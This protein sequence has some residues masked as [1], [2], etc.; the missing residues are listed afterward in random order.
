MATTPNLITLPPTEIAQ[1]AAA[2]L[3]RESAGQ[4]SRINAIN[5]SAFMLARGVV[6]V[7]NGFDGFLIASASRAGVIHRVSH[8][9]GCNC[10]AGKAGRP[11]WHAATVEILERA[12]RYTMPALPRLETAPLGKP[13]AERIA[14]ARS[15]RY[16]KALQE[17]NEL[18]G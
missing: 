14:A 9:E 6:E 16:T 10:E 7:V 12:G 17:V 13:L 1:R 2:E 15:E 18:F 8:T 5:K 4:P 3:A 11:C